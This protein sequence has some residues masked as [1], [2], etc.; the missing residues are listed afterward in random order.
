MEEITV[1]LAAHLYEGPEATDVA[2]KISFTVP[3]IETIQTRIKMAKALAKQ[4]KSVGVITFEDDTVKT[5]YEGW[6]SELEGIRDYGDLESASPLECSSE[7]P[8][9]APLPL[10]NPRMLVDSQSVSFDG[11]LEGTY[12]TIQ[13]LEIREPSL[14]MLLL[15]LKAKTKTAA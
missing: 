8:L 3:L 15:R 9:E 1:L 5:A 13:S 10:T 11:L 7:V 2:M 4:D 6:D 14:Q 12:S